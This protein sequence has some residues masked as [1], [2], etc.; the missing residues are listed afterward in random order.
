L[1]ETA[2]RRRRQQPEAQGEIVRLQ[3]EL[4]A[5]RQ[6]LGLQ[7]AVEELPESFDALVG[8]VGSERMAVPLRYV[9]EVVPRVLLS[10]LPE[11]KAH[12]AGY[13]RWR[14]AHAPVID[15]G[16][17]FTGVPL[18]IRLEDRILVVRRGASEV[19]GLLLSEIEGVVRIERSA[20][21]PVRADAP[22]ADW[23]LGF[24]QQAERPLL[25][26]SLDELLRPLAGLEL[27]AEDGK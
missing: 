18:P 20:L 11:A 17:R 7:A 10:P 5:L 26:V 14:G 27:P 3:Q 15:M 19:R 9:L 13:M 22:G 23:A 1:S 4:A 12:V 16:Q 24:L 21:H 8:A 2:S 25:V 6:A